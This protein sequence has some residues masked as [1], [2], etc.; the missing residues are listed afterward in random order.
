MT[1]ER[2]GSGQRQSGGP[3]PRRVL[4]ADPQHLS[5]SRNKLSWVL[6]ALLRVAGGREAPGR[7]DGSQAEAP[8]AA[9][10]RLPA[11]QYHGLSVRL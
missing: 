8:P 9:P 6:G 4:L 1:W 5:Q 3:S 2:P 10:G 7:G 11:L